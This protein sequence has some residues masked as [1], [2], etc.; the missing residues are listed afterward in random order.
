MFDKFNT[1]EEFEALESAQDK[2]YRRMKESEQQ[3]EIKRLITWHNK[4]NF[5]D[6][7][8]VKVYGR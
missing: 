2:E 3:L 5:E 1:F 4:Y 8:K 7:T 6:M